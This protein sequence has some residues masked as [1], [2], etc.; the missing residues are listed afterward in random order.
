MDKLNNVLVVVTDKCTCKYCVEND[1]IL[2]NYKSTA[3]NKGALYI[4][5]PADWCHN[6]N[7]EEFPYNIRVLGKL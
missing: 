3:S 5:L 2:G 7:I 4:G 6:F 1:C